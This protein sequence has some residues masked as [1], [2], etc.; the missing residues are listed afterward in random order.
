MNSSGDCVRKL[1]EFFKL[2]SKQ[3]V[4]VISDD[5]DLPCG[6]VRLR[7]KGGP[8]THNGLKSIDA[9][10]GAGKLDYHR[11]RI[12]I[13]HPRPLGLPMDPV[14]YVLG[15]FSDSELDGLDPVLDRVTQ[16]IERMVTGDVKGAMTEFNAKAAKEKAEE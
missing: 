7:M 13:G 3:Q 9:A 6:E 16:A 5:I 12:G 8:G 4:L 14:D 2:D 11:V 10:L 15:R 1:V